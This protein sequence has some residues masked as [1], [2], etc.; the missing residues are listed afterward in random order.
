MKKVPAPKRT[1]VRILKLFLK[2]YFDNKLLEFVY[3]RNG[4]PELRG[5]FA[6]RDFPGVFQTL[7]SV[8][9]NPSLNLETIFQVKN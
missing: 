2:P 4:A 1:F 3:V 6:L 8:E 5:Y 9:V 7:P